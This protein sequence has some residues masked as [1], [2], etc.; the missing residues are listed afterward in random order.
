MADALAIFVGEHRPEYVDDDRPRRQPYFSHSSITVAKATPFSSDKET[1]AL[2]TP[3]VFS[4]FW[5]ASENSSTGLPDAR[6]RTQTPCQFAGDLMP[7]PSAFVNAS[8][9]AKRLA[10]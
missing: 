4:N 8:L 10:R 7:V 1:C 3:L 5:S 6:L 9:A 2:V